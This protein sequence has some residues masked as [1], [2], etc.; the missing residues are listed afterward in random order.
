M[1]EFLQLF[2]FMLAMCAM[3]VFMVLAVANAVDKDFK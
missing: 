2:A 3:I 1:L